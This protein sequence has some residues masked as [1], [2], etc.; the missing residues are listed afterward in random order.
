MWAEK[1]FGKYL[2]EQNQEDL[3]IHEPHKIR[4]ARS[5]K[6]LTARLSPGGWGGQQFRRGIKEEQWG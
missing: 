2:S 3:I 1:R 6:R 5:Y 4:R